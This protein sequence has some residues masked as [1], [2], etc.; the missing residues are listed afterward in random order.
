MRAMI[1]LD[2]RGLDQ[3]VA[4]LLLLMVSLAVLSLALSI[5]VPVMDQ[6]SSQNRI[7]EAEAL[8]MTL[9]NEILKVQEEPPG[10]R[11]SI[12]LGI[13]RG[14]LELVNNPPS[15]VSYV[16]VRKKVEMEVQGMDFSY[17]A[18]GAMLRKRLALPLLRRVFIGP[19]SNR[20]TITKTQDRK[21]N[22]TVELYA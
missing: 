4:Q 1:F 8:I 13:N 16:D 18:K 20:V 7:K 10:S 22:V 15:I 6:Y 2:R 5:V 19:G 9:Y 17:T 3:V 14:G 21:L 11:R 12:E